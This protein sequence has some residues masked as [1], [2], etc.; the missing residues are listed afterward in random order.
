MS[1][2]HLKNNMQVCHQLVQA[3]KQEGQDVISV[4]DDN[5]HDAHE[6]EKIIENYQ[7]SYTDYENRNKYDIS[8]YFGNVCT[9]IYLTGNGF[10]NHVKDIFMVA[11]YTLMQTLAFLWLNLMFWTNLSSV[12]G[13]KSLY[14]ACYGFY[15]HKGVCDSLKES[16]NHLRVVDFQFN[17]N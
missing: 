1:F 12:I 5:L 3:Y 14:K 13:F 17:I 10:V 11:I 4:V 9:F 2:V 8:T 7:K 15:T 6:S 16:Y